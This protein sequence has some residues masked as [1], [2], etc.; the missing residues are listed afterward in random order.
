MPTSGDYYEKLFMITNTA[1]HYKEKAE[2]LESVVLVLSITSIF[3]LIL[4]PFAIYGFI[5]M[6]QL[7]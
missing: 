4:L 1:R 2:H 3:S 5:M 7:F 6:L